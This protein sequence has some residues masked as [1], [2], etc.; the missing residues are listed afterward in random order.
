MITIDVN[1][2]ASGYLSATPDARKI[3]V[4]NFIQAIFIKQAIN[5]IKK[6]NFTL[7]MLY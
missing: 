5:F 3:Q 1:A 7:L 4:I 2:P 6:I